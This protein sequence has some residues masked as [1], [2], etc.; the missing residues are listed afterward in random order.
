MSLEVLGHSVLPGGQ[1][2]ATDTLDPMSRWDG[3]I[4]LG[5]QLQNRTAELHQDKL[6]LTG[7][8]T[9]KQ[10]RH[11]ISRLPVSNVKDGEMQWQSYRYPQSMEKRMEVSPPV[12]T[13][14]NPHVLFESECHKPFQNDWRYLSALTTATGCSRNQAQTLAVS[15]GR[16]ENKVGIQ[17]LLCCVA[18]RSS[19]Q[20]WAL[21]KL[22]PEGTKPASPWK[23][24]FVSCTLPVCETEAQCLVGHFELWHFSCWSAPWTRDRP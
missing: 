8:V 11:A 4:L 12:H 13:V 21:W 9:C 7:W 16:S 5:L 10:H 24:F 23:G 6:W 17:E 22:W 1:R 2:A 15:W 18:V 14:M 3:R 19:F 20:G